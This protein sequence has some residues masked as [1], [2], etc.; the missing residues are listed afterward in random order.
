MRHRRKNKKL[1]RPTDQR[2]AVLREL[3]S[4][5]MVEGKIETTEARA[6]EARRLAE[7]IITIAKKDT[8]HARREVR[9]VLRH[10]GLVKHVFDEVM[11]AYRERKGGYTRVVRLGR[12]RGDGASMAMLE[13]VE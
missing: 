13:L 7:R 10:E 11:P 8:L 3:V 4:A 12:R 2:L 1:G 6:R 5:L 9:K